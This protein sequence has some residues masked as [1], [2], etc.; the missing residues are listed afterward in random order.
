MAESR[1]AS[2]DKQNHLTYLFLN[3]KT[4]E[5][6]IDVDENLEH[7]VYDGMNMLFAGG[8]QLINKNIDFPFKKEF[9]E[10]ILFEPSIHEASGATYFIATTRNE[11]IH[12]LDK[13]GNELAGF[14][15]YGNTNAT[16]GKFNA[17]GKTYLVGGTED[18]TLFLYTE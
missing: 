16:I 18:G 17:S 10:D 7:F 15:V 6:E 13:G 11:Q 12:A 2:I 9:D 14:P 8:N 3:D 5:V 1:L 4:D